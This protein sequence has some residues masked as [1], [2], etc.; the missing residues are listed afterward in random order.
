MSLQSR[1]V[2]SSVIHSTN[3][4]VNSSNAAHSGVKWL[5]SRSLNSST[6]IPLYKLHFSAQPRSLCNSILCS[7][8]RRLH[9]SAM[10]LD[11]DLAARYQKKTQR[12]H[13]LLRPEPY[14]G[15]IN[16]QTQHNWILQYNSATNRYE[17]QLKQLE[18]SAA[19]IHIFDE[20]LVN[21]ADNR[22]RNT[23]TNKMTTISV[24]IDPAA[25]TI[26]V[27]N[28]GAEIPIELHPVEKVY[29]PELIFGHLLTS[30]NYND[31]I[32]RLT[33]GRHGYGAKLTNIFSKTFEI[34]LQDG[35]THYKQTFSDN[36]A[37][38]GKP[39]IEKS[40]NKKTFTRITFQPDLQRFG[41]TNLNETTMSLMKKRV[42]DVAAC[43]AESDI[44]V[45]YNGQRVPI[46]KF[47]DY[48]SY[49]PA[50]AEGKF[51]SSK[52]NENWQIS[53]GPALSSHQ[54]SNLG[55]LRDISFVNSIAT[56]R[57]GSHVNYVAEQ[58]AL[59]IQSHLQKNFKQFAAV[60]LALIRA[61]FSL[62]INCNISNP[63]FQSQ[64]KEL[65]I[66]PP[67]KF[68]QTL[69][70]PANWLNS[71]V[72]H[73]GIVENC[74]DALEAKQKAELV[75][76]TRGKRRNLAIPKL[77]DANW[78]GGERGRECTLILTEGDSAKALVLS[79]LSILGRDTFGVFPLR[80][81]LLNVRDA[82][83]EQIINNTEINNVVQIM[84][85]DHN[86]DYS[87]AE[88]RNK[89]RYG[90]IL[91]CTDQDHD[92]SHIKGLFI[93]ILHKFWPSL[94]KQPDFLSQ[95]VTAIIKVTHS[96]SGVVKLFHSVP[97]FKAWYAAQPN[98]TLN[99]WK[100][101]YYKGLGT[102]TSAEGREYFK[103]F[104]QHQLEFVWG[105]EK[106]SESIELAFSKL[107]ADQRKTWLDGWREDLA[108]DYSIKQLS[109]TDFINKELIQFSHYDNI[110]SIPSAID[111]L[112]P[113]QR[114]ILFA[115]F[116]RS[117]T[118]E[119]KVAQ[120]SGYIAEQTNYHHGEISLQQAIVNMAQDF[121]GSNNLPLLQPIG[122]F[123]TRNQG[124]KDA[125]SPRYIFTKLSPLARLIFPAADDSIL[126]HRDEDGQ[127]VEPVHF[128]P[129]IPLLLV[130]GA[131]GIGTGFSTLIPSYNPLDIIA[132][133][134]AKLNGQN[135]SRM[136]PYV[137]NLSGIIRKERSG[138]NFISD[139]VISQLN[140]EVLEISELPWGRWTQDYKEYLQELLQ[141][142]IIRRFTEHHTAETVKFRV[143]L[144]PAQMLG[145]EKLGLIKAFKLSSNISLNNMHA[146]DETQLIKRFHNELEVVEQ[147]FPVR[148]LA[149][150]QRKAAQLSDLAKSLSKFDNKIK[151]IEAVINERII[152]HRRNKAELVSLLNEMKFSR[153]EHDSYDYLL[154]L[155]L[156]SLTRD[157]VAA[158][159][160]DFNKTQDEYNVLFN[161]TP[162]Q[163]WLHDLNQLEKHLKHFQSGPTSPTS[164]QPMTARPKSPAKR[165]QRVK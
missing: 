54:Y 9:S 137:V 22:H 101:K 25:S 114:K 124:G 4:S 75:K 98:S 37:L 125:A 148:L 139:G 56:T 149:Y 8:I 85:L 67:S 95:F 48:I 138:G 91:L 106:D 36:M 136:S 141:S 97:D 35:K 158:L 83:H 107:L 118:Q 121:P 77:D 65:L 89:L 132:N 49:F 55:P 96:S 128:V 46:N 6:R 146:F 5:H 41:E 86:Q 71:V 64:T 17:M 94:L 105:G 143:S 72:N 70:F 33:G 74:V 130:N 19:L 66:T 23:N 81:K 104:A 2:K 155:P 59:H 34:E 99:K 26:S 13:I 109:F 145:A 40:K 116:K 111:G 133:L 152:I 43:T 147:F 102:N 16:K 68:S 14:M 92:G 150:E 21:A 73:S 84:G 142:G 58:V 45:N 100:I 122:Q 161:L 165:L 12:E 151:F 160:D 117:L 15:D 82:S 76:K 28:D 29:V 52:I 24:E 18:Y 159:R 87:T 39:I 134:K 61:E 30:S 123:G 164:P 88:S 144:S 32:S 42:F 1:L 10:S 110:R 119:I 93:N 53:V 78:A 51:I 63:A 38:Q 20:I 120:F 154:N 153:D 163:L 131:Q 79:G 57:G 112:K 129:V 135:M 80:G 103:N 156:S 60:P 162:Q 108:L 127:S 31:N 115:A 126:R 44:T 157:R 69:K 90:R 50:P 113:A 11:S 47:E 3:F 140:N 27:Y 7:A 62:F